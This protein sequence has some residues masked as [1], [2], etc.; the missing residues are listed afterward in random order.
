MLEAIILFLK[1]PSPSETIVDE[2]DVELIGFSSSTP[3][4][5]F[6]EAASMTIATRFRWLG[7]D[8]TVVSVSG[9]QVST[10]TR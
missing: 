7:E 5:N 8:G 2:E 9:W 3:M 1:E 10:D 4:S 6:T